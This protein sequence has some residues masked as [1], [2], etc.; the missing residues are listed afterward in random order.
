MCHVVGVEVLEFGPEQGEA[1]ATRVSKKVN[2][3]RIEIY[4]HQIQPWFDQKWRVTIHGMLFS[5]IF[6]CLECGGWLGRS[7]LLI[8]ASRVETL[9]SGLNRTP[10]VC[11]RGL[12]F[13]PKKLTRVT[14]VESRLST[15]IA[16]LLSFNFQQYN[17]S[18]LPMIT[19]S[20]SEIL[21]VSLSLEQTCVACQWS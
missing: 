13:R 9:L 15:D 3:P 8:R 19:L 10:A 21:I 16:R 5:S 12:R 1:R 17:F 4:F 14:G 11:I 18:W 6:G 20:A 2:I 7:A